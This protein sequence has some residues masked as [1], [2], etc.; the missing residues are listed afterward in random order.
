MKKFILTANL[1]LKGK[2]VLEVHSESEEEALA[3]FWGNELYNILI[4]P[5]DAVELK[6]VKAFTWKPNDIDWHSVA[7]PTV[8]ELES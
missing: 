4:D 5:D 6:A 8:L 1:E 2:L 3:E 7:E